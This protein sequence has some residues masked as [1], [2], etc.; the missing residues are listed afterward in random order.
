MDEYDTDEVIDGN[1]ILREQLEFYKEVKAPIHIDKKNGQF[2]NG[3][4]LEI[5]GDMLIL[6]ENF[7]GATPIHFIEIKILEKFVKRDK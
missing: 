5:A 6:D 4:I 1:R 7:L 2:Y 3:Y